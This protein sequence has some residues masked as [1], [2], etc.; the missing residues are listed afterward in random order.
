M[1][2]KGLLP[3]NEFRVSITNLKGQI[4]MSTKYQDSETLD[5]SGLLVGVYHISVSL[6]NILIANEKLIISE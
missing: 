2:L 3:N 4:E 6:D 5:L 1:Q